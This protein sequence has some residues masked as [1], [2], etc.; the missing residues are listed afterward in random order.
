[1]N[2]YKNDQLSNII[3]II[4]FDSDEHTCPY[5][6]CLI[7]LFLT[8]VIDTI[9]WALLFVLNNLGVILLVTS[10]QPCA[11]QLPKFEITHPIPH[12]TVLHSV[13]IW[14][15]LLINAEVFRYWH[16][17]STKCLSIFKPLWKL[18]TEASTKLPSQNWH[19]IEG[20][21][22][23]TNVMLFTDCISMEVLGTRYQ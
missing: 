5:I 16:E 4:S 14:L 1:M 17:M 12:W 19:K 20:I 15:P 22:I 3:E 8:F 13:L 18:S 21:M 9:I 6:K 7:P 23:Q 2:K 11:M 10:N